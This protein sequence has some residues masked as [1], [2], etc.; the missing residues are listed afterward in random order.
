[1]V[2][3]QR[4]EDSLGRAHGHV[5]PLLVCINFKRYH[6]QKIRKCWKISTQRTSSAS[7]GSCLGGY[8]VLL[9]NI[10]AKNMALTAPFWVKMDCRIILDTW[11]NTAQAVWRHDMRHFLLLV[12][13]FDHRRP[14]SFLM[15][16]SRTVIQIRR[17]PNSLN[18]WNYQFWG[19]NCLFN[20]LNS[21]LTWYKVETLC[22][23]LCHVL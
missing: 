4:L 20:M 14:N 1:M 3:S 8:M 22:N 10:L 21:V 9:A 6:T 11:A 15:W 7:Y 16:N 2:S 5:Q 19:A 18:G 23:V 12:F 17:C 13:T